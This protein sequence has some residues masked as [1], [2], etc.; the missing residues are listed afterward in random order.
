MRHLGVKDLAIAGVIGVLIAVFVSIA[1]AQDVSKGSIAG[2]VRDA[3]SAVVADAEVTL[4][5][6]FGERKIKTNGVGE[7]V[8][9]NLTPGSDYSVTVQKQGFSLEKVPALTVSLNQ[10]TTANVTLQVGATAQTVEVAAV[11]TATVD[12]ASTGVGANLSEAL[13]KS[14]AAGRNISSIINFA[15]G[16]TSSQGAGVANPSINGASGLE[17]EYIING[18]DVTDSGFGGFGTYSRVFGPL[19]T[20]VNFDFIQEVQVKTGGFEAQ[21][22]QALGGVVNVIT[23]SGTNELHGSLYG[24]FAPQQFEATRPNANPQLVTKS[25]YREHQATYDFG[26]DLGGAIKKDKLFFYGGINPTFQ[27]NYDI[28]D[29]SFANYVLGTQVLKTFIPNY[30]GKLNWNISNKHTLEGTIF[31][32]PATTNTQ[33]WRGNGP[34]SAPAVLANGT[35]GSVDNLRASNLDY[36]SRTWSGRYT[37]TLTPTWIV[38]AAYT[39]HY[40]HF[41]ENPL[42]NGYLVTDNAVHQEISSV[43]TLTYG[44]LGSLENYESL[45]HIFN[46]SSSH[47]FSLGGSHSLDYGF[48]LEDQPYNDVILF[49]GP[50]ITLPNDPFFG[51]AA[52]QTLYGAT[53]TRTHVGMDPTKNVG[54]TNPANPNGP[55]VERVTRGN[56]SNPNV[57]VGSRYYSGFLQDSWTIGRHLTLKPGIRFE[58]QSMHGE[59]LH[60]TFAHN[61]APRLGVIYDP[62]GQRKSK[63]FGNWGR[64]YEKIPSD[65]SIRAFSFET[66]AIGA[67]YKDAGV[68]NSPD[69]SAANWCG[70]ATN[71][72]GLGIAGPALSFQGDPSF[73]E[74]VYGGTGAEYQD[75]VVAGYEKEFGNKFTFSGRFVYR[76]MRRII[77]DISGVNV[78]QANAS[79]PQQYVVA[80]P[81]ASLDIFHN[82]TPCTSGPNCDLMSG[83]NDLNQPILGSD[84]IPDGFPNASRI[85]KAME[86]VVGRRFTNGMQFYGSYVLSKLYGNFQGSFRGDNG[87]TDPN[88]SSLFDFTNSDG[89]LTGQTTPGVLPTDR[90]HQFKFYGNYTWKN[91]N[92]GLS[93]QILSGVPITKLMDHPVYANN[94][95]LPICPDG[96]FSCPGGPRGQFGRSQWQYPLDFHT[97]YTRKLTEKVNLKVM[98]D[99][100][101][102]FNTTWVQYP[103]M[104]GELNNSPG[105]PNPDFLKPGGNGGTEIRDAYTRPF[106]AR[107]GVRFEF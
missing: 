85:Y 52:G 17:N 20:G 98:A 8:F 65:I 4:S 3:T 9:L 79:V 40:N 105:I 21:Y 70:A 1:G 59:F 99:L 82:F 77:E 83:Y 7:Y 54:S 89:L 90:R 2:V 86:L 94:G 28:A 36:G 12:M 97:D 32:D 41:S 26:A 101:D 104:S 33:Y 39:D 46:V 5:S 74:L 47:I 96:T 78:T 84:G 95:E 23:K 14:V 29:P 55:I 64:F 44:G 15:P 61:W 62:T 22:G 27:R 42:H 103:D 106:Y 19:G 91:L 102:L 25:D 31:G 76:N 63:F 57:Q 48:Q 67:Y 88:I 43:G 34:N 93:W 45:N 71:P 80:N 49:S 24:Y 72:C 81:S 56:Y 6:P 35:P 37:G 66:S 107:L 100:F 60:Y 13:Y 18:S 10:R 51:T 92:F 69:L 75:E 11:A 50:S 87:Q 16:V 58:Q 53:V 73:A 68:G 38:T 30:T